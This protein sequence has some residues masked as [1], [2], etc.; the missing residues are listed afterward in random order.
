MRWLRRLSR[1]LD[2]RGRTTVSEFWFAMLVFVLGLFV[3]QLATIMAMLYSGGLQ[4]RSEVVVL[5]RPLDAARQ[6]IGCD[7]DDEG[8]LDQGHDVAQARLG[9]YRRG[10]VERFMTEHRQVLVDRRRDDEDQ[11]RMGGGQRRA[12]G[13]GMTRSGQGLDKPEIGGEAVDLDIDAA[14][15]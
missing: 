9:E 7:V 5:L 3:M 14:S 4:G 11:G 8:G 13:K 10:V 2:P 6:T 12:P 1:G 15:S